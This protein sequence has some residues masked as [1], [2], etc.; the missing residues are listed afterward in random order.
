MIGST[1][2]EQLHK[3][4]DILWYPKMPLGNIELWDI[5]IKCI[6]LGWSKHTIFNRRKNS[7]VSKRDFT[8]KFKLYTQI[9]RFD[10]Q[11]KFS[12]QKNRELILSKWSS[13]FIQKKSFQINYRDRMEVMKFW[14]G[15]LFNFTNFIS[16]YYN[17]CSY[18]ILFFDRNSHWILFKIRITICVRN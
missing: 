2:A 3:F 12:K 15:M 8:S 18:R 11:V 9:W 1:Q 17:L 14:W 5:F 7:S 16:K 13:M 10:I 4:R 6:R